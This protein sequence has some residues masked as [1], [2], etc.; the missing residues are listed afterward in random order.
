MMAS[1]ANSLRRS[2]SV[3]IG[4]QSETAYEYLCRQ[5][6]AKRWLES[7]LSCE[8]P[9]APALEE[10]L[11]NGVILCKLGMKLL[12]DDQM[13]NRV[14]DL[15]QSKFKNK[16]L[17][18]R[19]TDNINFW[20]ASLQKLGLPKVFYPVM[21]DIYHKK[22]MPKL[23]YC[24]HA[25]SHLL[26]GK[27]MVPKAVDDLYG[28]AKFPHDAIVLTTQ[29]LR[30]GDRTMPTFGLVENLVE[31]ELQYMSM[32]LCESYEEEL[33]ASPNDVRVA[34][35]AGR[36]LFDD[37]KYMTTNQAKQQVVEDEDGL[38]GTV[39]CVSAQITASLYVRRSAIRKSSANFTSL[40][41]SLST[42]NIT[43][44]KDDPQETLKALQNP[45]ANFPFVYRD[46]EADK[47]HKALIE[48]KKCGMPQCLLPVFAG[49]DREMCENLLEKMSPGAF[50]VRSSQTVNGAYVFSFKNL[51][52]IKHWKL[53]TKA[54]KFYWGTSSLHAS[55]E[56]FIES[57][58]KALAEATKLLI[59]CGMT[60]V[61][62]PVFTS[63]DC[64]A[65]VTSMRDS[66]DSLSYGQ[67]CHV[68]KEVNNSIRRGRISVNESSLTHSS[69]RDDAW[70][71]SMIVSLNR[72][73]AEAELELKGKPGSFLVRPSERSP[74]DYAL[75]F[76]TN[77]DTRHWR[78]VKNS[79]RF[80]V[81][82]RPNPYNSLPEIIQHFKDAVGQET[83]LNMVPL[84]PKQPSPQH[85]GKS[86]TLQPPS[87]QRPI[88][89]VGI[90]SLSLSKLN[91]ANLTSWSVDDV[92]CWLTQQGLGRFVEVFQNNAV[93]GECLLALDNTLVKDDLGITAL[94]HR[95]RILKRVQDLKEQFHPQLS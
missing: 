81:H 35:L 94:G 21:T 43:L 27:G 29:T 49:V 76:R 2:S 72:L 87:I 3:S 40:E 44:E 78:I 1:Q 66:D 92:S 31:E 16:G 90:P 80:Y 10:T 30:A 46:K 75:A 83:G 89:T 69:V 6:E 13:W 65:T 36:P 62:Q 73:E 37:P 28:T 23:F 55:L 5:E 48:Q 47:Y 12:P 63:T 91:P 9:G 41:N 7:V 52:G 53:S 61:L 77:T 84:S 71:E 32:G 11:Q 38:I 33:P 19:Y 54:G 8:L 42:L 22:N 26:K 39:P 50:V 82:P 93:D 51:T 79:G 25:L 68:I 74:G 24:L 70:D 60:S 59:Y 86:Q 34:P 95:S 64:E 57:F 67:V 20:L 45:D 15:D 85:I 58:V 18:Y 56:S 17:D 4:E 88:S 14:Y